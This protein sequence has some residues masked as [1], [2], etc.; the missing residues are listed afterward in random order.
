[1]VQFGGSVVYEFGGSV[2]YEFAGGEEIV[3][4]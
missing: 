1:M 4:Y 3:L 2:V